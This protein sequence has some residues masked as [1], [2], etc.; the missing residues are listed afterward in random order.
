MSFRDFA[1]SAYFLLLPLHLSTDQQRRWQGFFMQT[2]ILKVM[3][4]GEAQ[5]VPSKKQ[6]GG[7]IAKN[8]IRLKEFGG[9]YEDEY[10]CAMYGNL[11]LCK[12]ATDT[13]VVAALRFNTH[14]ANGM[15]FQDVIANDM[16]TI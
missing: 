8:W 13:V 9:D 16:R 5:Y 10:V 2:K 6:D 15:V 12:F 11:A 14:E 7:Q 1:C 4:Q 3:A